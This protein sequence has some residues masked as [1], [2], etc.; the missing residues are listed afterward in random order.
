MYLIDY[1][2]FKSVLIC[3]CLSLPC[4]PQVIKLRIK[5]KR[6]IGVYTISYDSKTISSIKYT[7]CRINDDICM[8]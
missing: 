3:I 5:A 6:T 8:L 7:C 2:M 1:L 4:R